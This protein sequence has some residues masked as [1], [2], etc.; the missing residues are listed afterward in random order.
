M[1]GN[2]ADVHQF[3]MLEKLH[4]LQYRSRQTAV[5]ADPDTLLTSQPTAK[6]A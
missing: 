4:G 3:G 5:A 1:L 2:L 6:V